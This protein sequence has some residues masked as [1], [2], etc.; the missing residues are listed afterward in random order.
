MHKLTSEDKNPQSEQVSENA[1][2]EAISE[3][4]PEPTND[5]KDNKIMQKLD[6][7]PA[8]KQSKM[9]K[10]YHKYQKSKDSAAV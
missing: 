9:L 8:P 5:H 6:R 2:P 10:V 4:N 1:K 3:F 7:V